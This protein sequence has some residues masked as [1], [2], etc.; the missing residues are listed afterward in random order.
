MAGRWQAGLTAGGMVRGATP[1][2][3]QPLD[4]RRPVAVTVH[5]YNALM[6]SRLQSATFSGIEAIRVEVEVDVAHKGFAGTAVVGLPDAAVKES[7]ERVRSAVQ[8][9]GY[10]FPRYKTVINLAP[11]DLRKEG[12]AF[13]LPIGLGILF[14]DGQVIAETADRYLVTG[15][16]ALDGRVRPVKGVLSAAMLAKQS[17][18][19]GII[20]PADNAAEAAVVDGIDVIPV[21]SLTQATG[22]LSGQLPLEPV[23]IDLVEV[24]AMACRY[25]C[26]FADVR[27]QEQVKRA[28]TIAA[29]GMH[30]VLLIGPPGSGK[31]MLAKRLPTI[32]PPLTLEES[33]ETTRIHSVS[34]E[35]PPGVPML[36][37][38]PVRAPHHSASTPAMV[39]GG[40]VPA[41]GEISLAHYGVLFLD[42]FPE[43]QRSVLESL[44][45]PLEEGRV[46]IARANSTVSFPASFM[47]IAAMNPCPCGYLT[48]ARKACKCTPVQIERYLSR[49]SGPLIDRIDIHV[50]VPAVP[51]TELRSQRD[52]TPSETL[53]E[54]V[55]KARLRQ[56]ARFNGN[57]AMTNA[58]LTGK[59]LREYSHLDDAGERVLKQAMTELGLS[60]RAHDKILRVSRTIA[61]LADR[62]TVAAED[63]LEAVHYRRLDR[64]L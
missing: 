60:A 16:L 52:G 13:D 49:I 15:E 43:F 44:R 53:R 50:D 64:Q 25:D 31:T 21:T 33:L 9:S 3:P 7:I 18:L 56:R 30:N 54:Q 59:Q 14:A 37:T 35:L 32:L 1:N 24:F 42:E 51:F 23:V 19:R 63:V 46:T 61:D 4:A 27:G 34:G 20:V 39:G 6:V 40:S 5:D 41:A 2:I 10:E 11:A 58:R 8:N 36:A 62:D 22:F 45:Q 38:R 28:V 57:P 55:L 12:P 29:A 26:D 17:Q 48:D 47:M